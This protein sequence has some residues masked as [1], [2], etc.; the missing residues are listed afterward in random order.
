MPVM[1]VG[2]EK[3]FAALRPRLFTGSVSSKAAG[4]VSAAIAAANPGIDLGKLVPGVVLQIPEGLADVSLAEGIAF[5]PGSQQA[6]ATVLDAARASVA[7]LVE[8]AK[9][10]QA[11]DTAERGPVTAALDSGELRAL[12]RKDKSL[13]PAIAAAQQTLAGADAA[14]KASLDALVQAQGQ[15]EEELAAVGALVRRG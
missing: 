8:A 5:D 10:Q 3:N 2:T 11:A 9:A 1:I 14:D 6:I 15:W 12:R 4:Q 13:G 7:G